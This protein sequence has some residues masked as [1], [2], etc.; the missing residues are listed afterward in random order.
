MRGEKWDKVEKAINIARMFEPPEGYYLCY[1]GGKDSVTVKHI[2]DMAGVKYDTHYSVTTVDPPELVRFI[3]TQFKRVIYDMP[4]GSHKYYLTEGEHLRRCDQFDGEADTIHFEIPKTPMRKLIPKKKMPPTR[5][6]R[7]CCEV[8]K[9]NGGDGRLKVTGVRAAE[10]VARKK[11]HGDVTIMN[12]TKEVAGVKT[13][14]GGVV[15]NFDDADSRR[16]VEQCYRTHKTLVNPILD[17]TE[18]DVWE[19]ISKYDLQYCRLYNEGQKRIGC[20][21]CPMA[22]TKGQLRGFER[23]P[24]Y[25]KL[26]VRAF[27]DMLVVRQNAGLKTDWQ[28]GEDVMS[29]WLGL[30]PRT[31]NNDDGGDID[32]YN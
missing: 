18:A 1:S 13:E 19:F 6:V 30:K 27:D 5:L 23:W 25:R 12:P 24:Q 17:F 21:G 2:L 28:T 29:W 26:Y 31:K 11:G 8:L 7:Y 14:K 15:L 9:E 3:I 32:A 22:N 10:S 4:D 20:V 16:I